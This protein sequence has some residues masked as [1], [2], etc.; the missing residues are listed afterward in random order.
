MKL[1][2]GLAFLGIL[3][4]LAAAGVFMMREGR[5]GRSGEG[6][7][8]RALALRVALSVAV[9]LLILFA[10]LMGWIQPTGLPVGR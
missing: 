10:F 9:F 3:G 5:S 8:M 7:M 4:A 1:F 6:R 2:I